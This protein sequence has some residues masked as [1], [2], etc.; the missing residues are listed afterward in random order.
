MTISKHGRKDLA[1]GE[2]LCAYWGSIEKKTSHSTRMTISFSSGLL[3]LGSRFHCE[4][5]T[6]VDSCE[7][8]RHKSGKIVGGDETN[9]NEFPSMAG[10]VDD[11]EGIICG[12]TISTAIVHVCYS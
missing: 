11:V 1:D 10:L 8:G 4:I 2:N 9:V 6:I 3:P 5:S 7:C 12:A